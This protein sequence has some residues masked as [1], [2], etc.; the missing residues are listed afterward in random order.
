MI[1]KWGF[2]AALAVIAVGVVYLAVTFVQVWQASRQDQARP[3]QAIVVLGSAQYNGVPSPDLRA[4]LNHAY[5]LWKRNLS[6]VI[7]V[8]GGKQPG[9][10]VSEATA[11]ADY[12][13]AKGVPQEAILRE[14]SGRNSWQSLESTAAFLMARQRTTV[15]LVSDPFHDKR[16]ALI[17]GELGLKPYVSPTRSSPLGTGAKLANY[18]K[19]TGEV[20]VGRIIGFRHLVDLNA[21]LL[22]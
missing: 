3:V 21:W 7:V 1:V 15:L 2:R 5:D 22:G 18:V 16:I 10:R 14:V 4:R 8:T 9:D 13:A 11:S 17:A 19:E 20:A 12:L 6:D